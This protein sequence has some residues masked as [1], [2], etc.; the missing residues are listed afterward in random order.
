MSTS[1]GGAGV[2]YCLLC[3]WGAGHPPGPGR[4]AAGGARVP[5]KSCCIPACGSA[6]NSAVPCSHPYPETCAGSRRQERGQRD[7]SSPPALGSPIRDVSPLPEYF[8][9]LKPQGRTPA[10]PQLL[11]SAGGWG[12]REGTPQTRVCSKG[13][14]SGSTGAWRVP[15]LCPVGSGSSQTL[16]R[17]AGG[18]RRDLLEQ[19]EWQNVLPCPGQCSETLQLRRRRFG[20]GGLSILGHDGHTEQGHRGLARH[21]ACGEGAPAPAPALPFPVVREGSSQTTVFIFP[22]VSSILTY[23]SKSLKHM[24]TENVYKQEKCCSFASNCQ[25]MLGNGYVAV[26]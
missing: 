8:R 5:G 13:C 12:A 6:R 24:L 26:L 16:P 4:A 25:A 14:V 1:C 23:H 3:P 22:Q 15:A 20:Q 17:A 21:R 2:G 11:P 19:T 18:H 10:A 7:R 9:A